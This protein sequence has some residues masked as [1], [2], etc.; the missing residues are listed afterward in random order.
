MYTWLGIKNG[1]LNKI[2]IQ[3]N[4]ERKRKKRAQELGIGRCL[5]GENLSGSKSGSEQTAVERIALA[6]KG[7]GMRMMM[8]LWFSFSSDFRS[9][10]SYL[11]PASRKF[12]LWP[13]VYS[14]FVQMV[15]EISFCSLLSKARI[16]IILNILPNIC[17]NI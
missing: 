6:L 17:N 1:C 13:S 2:L 4:I 11:F 14:A 3:I 16:P 15:S 5:W 8:F 10:L 12:C 7:S 9:F